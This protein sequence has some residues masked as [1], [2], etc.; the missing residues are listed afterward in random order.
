MRDQFGAVA[1]AYAT[2]AVH[3]TGPDLAALI[4]AAGLSGVERVLDMGC[5][6]GHTAIAAAARAAHVTALDVT[7]QMLDVARGLAGERGLANLAFQLGDVMALPFENAWFDVVTSRLSAHHYAD[8][9]RALREA[10]RVLKPGGRFLLVDTIAPEDATLD[11]FNNCFELLRDASHVRNWRASE[12]LRMLRG[13]GFDEAESLDRY[14]IRL[15]GASWVE[16]MRT[17]P[18]KVSM[19]RELFRDAPAPVRAAFEIQD[20]PWMFSIP[21]VLARA[22]KA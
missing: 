8:P 16:R 22:A 15:D 18:T 11:T 7:P 2:S 14:V 9:A 6:A 19:L 1:A 20:D 5:G 3:A 4:E 10:Y 21:S 12:W 13:A 17:P